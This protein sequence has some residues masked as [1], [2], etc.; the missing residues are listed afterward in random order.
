MRSKIHEEVWDRL[1]DADVEIAYPHTHLV[2][3]ETS[4]TARVAVDRGRDDA[5]PETVLQDGDSEDDRGTTVA[6]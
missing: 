1:E 6:D 5:R 2:F 3:D 4:G